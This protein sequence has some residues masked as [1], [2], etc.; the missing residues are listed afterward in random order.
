MR[1]RIKDTE[2]IQPE[3]SEATAEQITA[4]AQPCVLRGGITRQ[5]RT[6]KC[7]LWTTCSFRTVQVHLS[8]SSYELISAGC[9]WHEG[10][11]HQIMQIPR[12]SKTTGTIETRR[13]EWHLDFAAYS[14][15]PGG[16]FWKGFLASHLWTALC[17]A[18]PF[19][20]PKGVVYFVTEILGC[21]WW[22]QECWTLQWQKTL[23]CWT[24]NQIKC[25]TSA[26]ETL[27]VALKWL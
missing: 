9:N 5:R 10:R 14:G 12:W 13:A 8:C 18:F 23:I 2:C 20:S 24:Q 1:G 22:R 16:E 15:H 19:T 27:Q 17:D 26:R 7:C 6:G 25:K 3:K 4:A 21:S 11:H